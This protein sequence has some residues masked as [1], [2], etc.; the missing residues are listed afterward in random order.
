MINEPQHLPRPRFQAILQIALA[1][2]LITTVMA[3]IQFSGKAI[4]DNDGYYHI[5]WSKLLRESFPRL[6][7]FK[8]LP[9]TTLNEKEYVDHHYLYHLGLS[10]FT[11]GDLRLG[12]KLA[13]VAFSSLALTSLF[14]LLIIYRVPYAWLWL[15]P[16]VASS[17]P[18]LYRMSMTRAP[19]LSIILMS[20]GAYLI[21]ERKFILLTLL[22]FVFVWAYSLFPLILVMAL[23]HSVCIYLAERRVDFRAL[24]A[25]AVGIIAGLIINPYFPTNLKL[26]YEHL[27]MKV[28]ASYAVDVG[29]EWYP[30]DSWVLVGSSAVAFVIFLVAFA[31]FDIRKTT[32]DIKPLF[33]LLIAVVLMLMVFKSRRFIEYFPPF[34][35]L[36]GAFTIKLQPDN[37]WYAKTRDS[38]IAGIAAVVVAIV[39]LATLMINVIQAGR[40]VRSEADPF[41][42]QGASLWLA[43]NAP[44][45]TMVFNTDWDDFPMLFYYNPTHAYVAG[46]DP[47]YLYDKDRELWHL[48]ADITLGK[49]SDAAQLIRERFNAAYVFTDNDHTNFLNIAEHSSQ[50]KVVYKDSKTTVLQLTQTDRESDSDGEE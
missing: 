29:I 22:A 20:V 47:T 13:A 42:Y 43:E 16:L 28:T 49:R 37:A 41:A 14:A 48:Y 39:L 32:E 40:D 35:V 25:A 44:L 5:Q 10:L 21:L 4:L 38:V 46:L 1:F 34:A 24:L 50:F 7:P 31:A 45:G 33:F 11:F 36:L 8:A 9:L 3:L 6:P 30:Y 23:T 19:A 27:M 2:V 15:M 17:E 12:A 26:F 18:F